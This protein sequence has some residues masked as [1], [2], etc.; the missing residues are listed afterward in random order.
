[1]RFEGSI[2]I[3]F[4]GEFEGKDI[5]QI[6][7]NPMRALTSDTERFIVDYNLEKVRYDDEE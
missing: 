6:I 4:E 5:E 7:A 1:M 3:C 2:T